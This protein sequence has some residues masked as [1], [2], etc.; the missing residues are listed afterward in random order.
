MK[1][2]VHEACNDHD[3]CRRNDG[4]V[5][6]WSVAWL[7]LGAEDGGSNDTTDTSCTDQRGGGEGAL[8]LATQIVGLVG[9]D[10]GDVGVAGGG[11]E[12][13]VGSVSVGV[14]G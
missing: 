11:G 13:L 4:R 1:L 6:T 5:D 7:I 8:P 3:Q 12:E 14:N 9:E 10:G 2:E